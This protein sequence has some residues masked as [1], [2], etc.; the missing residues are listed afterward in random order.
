MT[1][2]LAL[3]L[4]GVLLG[5]GGLVSLAVLRFHGRRLG[6]ID[7]LLGSVL[8]LALIVLGLLPDAANA[9]LGLLSFR[10]GG[11]GRLIGLLILS[12]FAL[13]VLLYRGL[14]RVTQMEHLADRL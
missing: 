5:A 9:V 8:C 7:W 10:A 3:R 6:K 14:A 4:I 12:N 11:G 1:E 13:Y 2:M